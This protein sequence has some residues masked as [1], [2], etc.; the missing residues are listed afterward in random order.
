MELDT[1]QIVARDSFSYEFSFSRKDLEEFIILSGDS[2][3]IH[4][5]P[6]AALESPIGEMAIPGLLTAMIFSRVLGTIF[7]GHGTVYRSQ[8][9]EFL[10]P[11]VLG[12]R[13]VAHFRVLNVNPKHHRARID[14]T[15]EDPETGKICLEG[16]AVVINK[17]RL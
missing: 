8:S 15:V 12:V 17:R 14:T 11:V 7:P 9:L 4:L 16:V 10:Y 5:D 13:Y 2:N 3:D 6:Q 1:S